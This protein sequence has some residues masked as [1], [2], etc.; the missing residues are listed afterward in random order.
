MNI[1]LTHIFYNNRKVKPK[2]TRPPPQKTIECVKKGPKIQ[3]TK[4]LCN[5][6]LSEEES[7]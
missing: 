5:F 1:N 4:K 2:A 7:F 3:Q 6:L